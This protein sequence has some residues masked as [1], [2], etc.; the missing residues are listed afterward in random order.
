MK[1]ERDKNWMHMHSLRLEITYQSGC[2]NIIKNI[3]IYRFQLGF[4]SKKVATWFHVSLKV[5]VKLWVKF[6]SLKV[7]LVPSPDMFDRG[8]STNNSSIYLK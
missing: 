5:Y 6:F 2:T 1:N 8:I 3:Y 4:I 7:I